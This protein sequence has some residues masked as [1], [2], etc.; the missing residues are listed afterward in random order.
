MFS[1]SSF[2][3]CLILLNSIFL[4]PHIVAV[5]LVCQLEFSIIIASSGTERSKFLKS[6]LP[7]TFCHTTQNI[8]CILKSL[9]SFLILSIYLLRMNFL[10]AKPL[11][12]SQIIF[13]IWLFVLLPSEY[14]PQRYNISLHLNFTPFTSNGKSVSIFPNFILIPS[15]MSVPLQKSQQFSLAAS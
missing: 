5:I 3:F 1:I 14:C 11:L 9:K 13:C 10:A 4:H 7:I 6:S 2:T 8:H 12:H 15:R